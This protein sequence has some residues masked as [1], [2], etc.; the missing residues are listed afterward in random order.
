MVDT[1]KYGTDT[2]VGDGRPLRVKFQVRTKTCDNQCGD[3]TRNV[4]YV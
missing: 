3:H 4:F 1:M 2:A